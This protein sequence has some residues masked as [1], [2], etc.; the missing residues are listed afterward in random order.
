L[1]FITHTHPDAN[2]KI[3]RYAHANDTLSIDD[4]CDADVV[5]T[6]VNKFT[7]EWARAPLKAQRESGQTDRYGYIDHVTDVSPFLQV[8]FF[9]FFVKSLQIFDIS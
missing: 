1:Q 8:Y 4:L 7:T 9:F 5:I 3:L 2:L 6:T